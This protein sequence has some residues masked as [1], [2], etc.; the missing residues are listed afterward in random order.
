[1]KN[2]IRNIL[3]VAIVA[4]ILQLIWEY[5]QCGRFYV[6][7]EVTGHTRLM[8]SATFGDMNMSLVLYMLL[9][10]VNNDVNWI[11]KKWHKHDYVITILYGLFLSFYFEAHALYTGRWE[12]NSDNMPLFLNTNIGLL[13]VIQLIVL[14]PLIF[15]ISSLGIKIYTK[16]KSS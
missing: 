5:A 16:N 12:Y 2:F 6:V 7:D 11:L 9:I 15:Y 4:F 3:V 14:F 8:I 13:P 10:I 1:M